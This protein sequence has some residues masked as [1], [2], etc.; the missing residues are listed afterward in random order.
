MDRRGIFIQQ[1]WNANHFEVINELVSITNECIVSSQKPSCLSSNAKNFSVSNCRDDVDLYKHRQNKTAGPP[2]KK[3]K[4]NT[5]LCSSKRDLTMETPRSRANVPNVSFDKDL[6][7]SVL[8]EKL[9]NQVSC[10]D[11]QNFIPVHSTPITLTENDATSKQTK[12][13]SCS[14]AAGA[15]CDKCL[16]QSTLHYP[17]SLTRKKKSDLKNRMFGKRFRELFVNLCNLCLE[18]CTSD[19]IG[20][21]HAWPSVFFTLL[22]DQKMSMERQLDVLTLLSLEMRQQWLGALDEFPTCVQQSLDQREI[23]GK[24]AVDGTLRLHRF[25]TLIKTLEQ[26]NIALALDSEPYPNVRCPF[27]C[28]CFIEES[29]FIAVKHFLNF[30]ETEFTC[31]QASG[32]LHLR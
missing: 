19:R 7:M 24:C 29:G 30:I 4:L 9:T 20:W 15:F 28:W 18:Y 17:F 25:Q 21:K 1:T 22:S 6:P 10:K 3:V 8:P 14:S 27:G 2:T 12:D 13:D 31:F 16:R 23:N 5:Y 26:E 32:H 11:I